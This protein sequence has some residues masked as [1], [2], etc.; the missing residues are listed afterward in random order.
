M[1]D[2]AELIKVDGKIFEPYWKIYSNFI[3]TM[4]A[5]IKTIYLKFLQ[6]VS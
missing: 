6:I 2:I 1:S 5:V 4:K 3:E